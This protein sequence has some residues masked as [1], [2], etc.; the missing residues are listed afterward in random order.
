MWCQQKSLNPPGPGC[1]W[2]NQSKGQN[3]WGKAL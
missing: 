3:K 1:Q 2:E